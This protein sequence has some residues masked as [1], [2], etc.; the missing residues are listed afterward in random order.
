MEGFGVNLR[1]QLLD[2]HG[3]VHCKELTVTSCIKS[4]GVLDSSTARRLWSRM[5]QLSVG[6]LH[7]QP[8]NRSDKLYIS[9]SKLRSSRKFVNSQAIENWFRLKGWSVVYPETLSIAEQMSV[10]SKARQIVGDDGSGLHNCVAGAPGVKVLCLNFDRTNLFHASLCAIA[11][12]QLAFLN[13]S[14]QVG[15]GGF[16]LPIPLLASAV[17]DFFE[18]H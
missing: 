10:F 2:S 5:R 16:Y 14:K 17:T 3:A 4:H 12:Q 7:R 15:N 13:S 18:A 11:D 8:L 6:E 1:P 9:R